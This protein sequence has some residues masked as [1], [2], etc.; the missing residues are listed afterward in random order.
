MHGTD[1][2]YRSIVLDFSVLAL[3]RGYDYLR[4]YDGLDLAKV[5]PLRINDLGGWQRF[6]DGDIDCLAGA[7]VAGTSPCNMP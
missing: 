7:G 5:R 6:G 1:W 2:V 3:E 4:V